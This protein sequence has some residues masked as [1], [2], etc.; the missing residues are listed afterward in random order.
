MLAM[1]VGAQ[2]N[3]S[4]CGPFNT[5]RKGGHEKSFGNIIRDEDTLTIEGTHT[6]NNGPEV[7]KDENVGEG[8][9]RRFIYVIV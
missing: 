8:A 6:V 9:G 2:I 5:C 1:V 4:G 3:L 7:K